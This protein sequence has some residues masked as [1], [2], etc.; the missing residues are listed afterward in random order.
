M[1]IYQ[2][3]YL[4]NKFTNSE[5][6]KFIEVEIEYEQDLKE[7]PKKR[8]YRVISS[9]MGVILIASFIISIIKFGN[10]LFWL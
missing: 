9:I 7:I 10:S 2:E 6:K 1:K 8:I 5:K 4:S 3:N